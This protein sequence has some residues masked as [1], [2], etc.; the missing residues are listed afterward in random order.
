MI[1]YNNYTSTNISH[2]IL[3][4]L[5]REI[6]HFCHNP[7]PKQFLAIFLEENLF[8]EFYWQF[9]ALPCV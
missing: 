9:F 4:A 8:L 7:I 6:F 3:Q 5:P 1:D 2:A